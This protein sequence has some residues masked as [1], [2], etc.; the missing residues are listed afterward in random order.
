MLTTEVGGCFANQQ[1][2]S[3]KSV[4]NPRQCAASAAPAWTGNISSLGWRNADARARVGGGSV[5]RDLV[6]W[7]VVPV[8]PDHGRSQHGD[9]LMAAR[10]LASVGIEGF[11][12]TWLGLGGT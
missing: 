3:Q 7:C 6:M 11:G 2:N 1:A 12:S 5:C 9:L 4:G 10:L 8:H